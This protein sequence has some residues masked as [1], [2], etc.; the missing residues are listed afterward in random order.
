MDRTETIFENFDTEAAETQA[1]VLY[2]TISLL[3]SMKECCNPRHEGQGKSRFHCWGL[4]LVDVLN[5]LRRRTITPST[6]AA[7]SGTIDRDKGKSPGRPSLKIPVE[8]LEELRGLGIHSEFRGG[9]LT[10]E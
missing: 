6:V 8:M 1:E 9:Q 10:D 3:R 4:T 2:Q 5:V 7:D